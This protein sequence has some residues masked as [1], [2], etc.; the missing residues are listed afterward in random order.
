MSESGPATPQPWLPG[1]EPPASGAF[2]RIGGRRRSSS[3]SA[4]RPPTIEKLAAQAS[5]RVR[6]VFSS[7]RSELLA[8]GLAEKARY[9]DSSGSFAPS[10]TYRD[11]EVVRLH[12]DP[13]LAA[14]VTLE[15]GDRQLAG[16]LAS[17][18]LPEKLK[19]HVVKCARR[20]GRRVFLALVVRNGDEI[21]S[22][23]VLLRERLAL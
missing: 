11:R 20:S 12:L 21:A 7:L 2:T 17:Q 9:D 6:K 14:T 5:P 16:L 4:P 22:L 15:R 23:L 1:L 3:R 18:A 13:V 8:A 19:A 10:Y